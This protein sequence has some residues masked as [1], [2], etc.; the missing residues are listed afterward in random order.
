MESVFAQFIGEKDERV[1]RDFRQK[2]GAKFENKQGAI[3]K[4]LLE[5]IGEWTKKN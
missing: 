4:A 1:I 3:K 5:A 2:A